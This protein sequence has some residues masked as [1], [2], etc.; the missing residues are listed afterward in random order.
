MTKKPLWREIWDFPLVSLVVAIAAF[1][2][3]FAGVTYLFAQFDI[4]LSKT[5]KIVLNGLLAPALALLLAK[6]LI[7]RLGD[8]RRDDLAW[9]GAGRMLLIGIAGSALLMTVIFAVVFAL[10]GYRV[11]GWGGMTSW[12]MLLFIAGLRAGVVEEVMFRGILFR[13]LEDFGGSWFALAATSAL[14]GVAHIMNPN[15]T[16]F[17]SL[18]IAVEAGVLLGGAYM[19]T[20]SLWLSIGLHFGWNVTQ[21]FVFDVPVSGNEVDGV[22]A[23]HPAG[24]VWLSGG[25]FG[26]E[27]SAVALAIAGGAG[28]WLTVKAVREGQLVRPW[29]TRR[30]LAREAE[31][32]A[33]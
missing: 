18:A 3:V 6:F 11:D 9:S 19:L 15:A 27:A 22:L 5:G 28:A 24:S 32:L 30:R 20:R 12:A 14:F 33:A 26:L 16:W 10:G 8:N 13:Y 2:A 29:W 7:P 23:A 4:P 25:E 1:V 17:S 31:A 21:G